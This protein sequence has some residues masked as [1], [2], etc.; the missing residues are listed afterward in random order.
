MKRIVRSHAAHREELQLAR[1][2]IQFRHRLGAFDLSL[3]ASVEAL[4]HE[5]FPAAK[6]QFLLLPL[7]AS[8]HGCLG[9]RVSGMLP[10]ESRPDP[11]RRVPPLSVSVAS[12]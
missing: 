8:P 7:C 11:A 4:R 5:H 6:P 2:L 12:Q 9:G 10:A 3:L 1:I